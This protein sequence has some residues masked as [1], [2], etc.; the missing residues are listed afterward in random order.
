MKDETIVATLQTMDPRDDGAAA[1]PDP[2]HPGASST[3]S[4]IC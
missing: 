1:F 4:V 3:W 2:A